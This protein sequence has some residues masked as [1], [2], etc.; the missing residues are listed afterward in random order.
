[1]YLAIGIETAKL[2]KIWSWE[3]QWFGPG[4]KKASGFFVSI[5]DKFN[6]QSINVIGH[7]R[8]LAK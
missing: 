7:M 5:P 6:H 3:F 8:G 4:N 1:M 2:V